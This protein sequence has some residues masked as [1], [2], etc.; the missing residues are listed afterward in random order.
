ME[1]TQ[2][3]PTVSVRNPLRIL[4]RKYQFIWLGNN[5]IYIVEKPIKFNILYVKVSQSTDDKL[6]KTNS[7]DQRERLA[8]MFLIILS[9][10]TLH[11]FT[12]VIIKLH[13]YKDMSFLSCTN[14]SEHKIVDRLGI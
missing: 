11:M 8:S 4:K 12:Y 3:A 13:V 7:A 10:I 9:L 6:I 5:L 2:S 14:I 1:F